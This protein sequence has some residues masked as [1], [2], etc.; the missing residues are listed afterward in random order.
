M[1]DEIGGIML[2]MA[3]STE[4]LQEPPSALSGALRSAFEPHRPMVAVA[5]FAV[6]VTLCMDGMRP[7]PGAADLLTASQW[8]AA[9]IAPAVGE[10]ASD[11]IA[12]PSPVNSPEPHSHG[13]RTPLE[14]TYQKSRSVVRMRWG[15]RFG[16]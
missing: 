5:A 4:P 10:P 14:V 9:P 16:P 13:V 8:A 7:S 1:R 12:L 3:H 6:A 2:L 15:G 11:A